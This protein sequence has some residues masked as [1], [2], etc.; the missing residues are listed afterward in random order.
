MYLFWLLESKQIP[1]IYI[2]AYHAYLFFRLFENKIPIILLHL[3]IDIQ[4]FYQWRGT[5]FTIC[6]ILSSILLLFRGNKKKLKI[7]RDSLIF[8]NLFILQHF[9]FFFFWCFIED[10]KE[11]EGIFLPSLCDTQII[12]NDNWRK[13]FSRK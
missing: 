2:S 5:V 1:R 11:N 13:R 12:K 9:F 7:L 3:Y 10:K 8:T 4:I 6:L